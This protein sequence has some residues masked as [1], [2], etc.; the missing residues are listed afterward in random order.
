MD[1]VIA[2]KNNRPFGNVL[3]VFYPVTTIHKNNKKLQDIGANDCE[4]RYYVLYPTKKGVCVCGLQYLFILIF[5][6]EWMEFH[7]PVPE[8]QYQSVRWVVASTHGP[9][10]LLFCFIIF[11]A[12]LPRLSPR[13]LLQ[14]SMPKIPKSLFHQHLFR[15]Q[16]FMARGLPLSRFSFSFSSLVSESSNFNF[17][18]LFPWQARR[19]VNILCDSVHRCQS[20]CK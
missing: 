12:F 13:T 3:V 5:F 1:L 20:H 15:L 8:S 2:L 18:S 7:F 9:P 11:I 4:F 6:Y 14:H 19:G 16:S 10:P 17:L